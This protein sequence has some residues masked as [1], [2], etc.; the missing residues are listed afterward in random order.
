MLIQPTD[1]EKKRYFKIE[2]GRTAPSSAA[3][4]AENV[5]KRKA[6]KQIAVREQKR[7]EKTMGL[8]KRSGVLAHPQT[9]GRLTR[10]FGIVD[11]ELPVAS[12]A[13]GLREKGGICFLP[14]QEWR[15]DARNISCMIINGDDQASGLGTAYASK[16]S[17]H[18][19]V[20][21]R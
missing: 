1:E 8:I 16:F 21:S 14:G 5:K 7:M 19:V 4:S 2:A 17:L 18:D 13:A 15:E 3:W 11:P 10:E 12:W 9:G 6:E 20:A